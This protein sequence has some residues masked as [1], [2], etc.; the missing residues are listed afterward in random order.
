MAAGGATAC[1]GGGHSVKK[2]EGSSATPSVEAQL[3]RT[4]GD[5]DEGDIGPYLS[6]AGGGDEKDGFAARQRVWSPG[7][8]IKWIKGRRGNR[9][10]ANKVG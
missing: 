4:T 9:E 10:K 1:M 6:Q 7:K 3:W 5:D 8:S 2:N